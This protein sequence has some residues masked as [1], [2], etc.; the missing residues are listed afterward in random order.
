MMKRFRIQFA[1]SLAFLLAFA[2]PLFA[3]SGQDLA[4]AARD[5]DFDRYAQLL[6]Q[7]PDIDAWSSDGTPALHWLVRF[8]DL[9]RVQAL[10]ARGA[11]T[12]QVNRYGVTPLQ[13]AAEFGYVA[14][15]QLL[16]ENGASADD[17]GPT[18]E[19]VLF[20]A[21][22]SGNMAAVRLL[23]EHGADVNASDPIF[24]QTALMVAARENN[25]E[26]VSLLLSLGARV[27]AYTLM[28]EVPEFRPP[29]AG[30]GSH[31][32]GI[33]RGGWPE[34]GMRNPVPGRLTALLYATRDGHT[35]V[36]RQ[37]LDA[38]ADI[39][40]RNANDTTPLTLAIMNANTEL[41]LLLVERGADVNSMDWYGQTPLWAAID[42]RN[43]ELNSG[44]M[45]HDVD[46]EPL[47]DLIRVLLE[48]GA[49]P[50]ARTRE[51]PP[52]RRWDMGLGSLSWVD[53]TG[54]T[55][56]LRAALSGDVRVMQ[57]LLE[58]G[59]DP[60]IPTFGGS[61]AL[62]AAAGV[63]WV[64]NQTYDEGQDALLE[65]VKLCVALGMDVNA[66]NSM[67][68]RAV[69]GAANRGSDDIIRYLH[70]QG[71]DLTATDNEGRSPLT[72]AEGVFLATHA[73][74]AKE[75]TIVLLNELQ[76]QQGQQGH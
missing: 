11:N 25:P 64:F 7:A 31:G 44:T 15:M 20:Y 9:P 19:P 49:D 8:N 35:N 30:G 42:V 47:F 71:A 75:S 22:R 3:D 48:Q 1:F 12:A 63:N 45:T 4:N 59:A 60:H 68:L 10:L 50:N 14:M 33:V 54:M 36:A 46:R 16:L 41:A 5:R 39:E 76:G 43:K 27:D 26:A 17:R 56:F 66:Q 51:V 62:M 73:P 18:G 38:G 32:V 52:L 65:A 6:D 61:T 28:G 70:A 58:H 2:R 13:I 37:L 29:G 21:I 69:H 24:E 40:A 67:G 74:F 34:Q 23:L 72:W 55:P 53:F 57:L